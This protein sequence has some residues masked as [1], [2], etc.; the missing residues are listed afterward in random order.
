MEKKVR[1]LVRFL[2][3]CYS[4]CKGPVDCGRNLMSYKEEA[5]V[6][7]WTVASQESLAKRKTPSLN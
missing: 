6:H 7:M 3:A 5:R 2:S 1:V 4:S